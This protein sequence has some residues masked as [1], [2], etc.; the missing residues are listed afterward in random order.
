MYPMDDLMS[1][2]FGCIATFT[3]LSECEC[4]S[5]SRRHVSTN[6]NMSLS[7]HFLTYA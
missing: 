3:K 1:C 2:T 5:G 6:H 4:T 7:W